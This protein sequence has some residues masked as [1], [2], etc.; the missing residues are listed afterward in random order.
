MKVVIAGGSGFIGRRLVRSLAADGHQSIVLSRDPTRSRAD[1]PAGTEVVGWAGDGT[2]DRRWMSSLAGADGVVSLVGRS[3]GGWPW[4]PGRRRELV[5][6]RVIPTRILVGAM[7]A[8]AAAARPLVFVSAS[9]TLFTQG[10]AD[11]PATE[12]TEPADAFLTRLCLRW[13]AEARAAERLGIR[14]VALRMSTV[15][16]RDAAALQRL[17]LPVRLFCGGPIGSGRQWLSWIDIRDAIGL[18]RFGLE[19]TELSGPVNACAPDPRRQADFARALAR[20]L[21]RPARLHTPARLVRLVMGEQAALILGS[22]RVSPEKAITAGYRFVEPL[23]EP[24][25]ARALGRAAMEAIPTAE[26]HLR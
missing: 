19:S 9:G 21:H 8:L 7:A 2:G 24:S 18:I 12:S 22:R 23:L 3:V 15:I 14:V 6:S 4:T 5:D 16:G 11:T 26:R 25:L 1:L 13:E 10:P 17:A 20:I